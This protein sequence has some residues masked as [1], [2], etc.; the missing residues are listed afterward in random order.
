MGVKLRTLAIDCNDPELLAAFW[1]AVLDWH[2]VSRDEM[3]RFKSV[4]GT[5][6]M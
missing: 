5:T 1:S 2:I 3:E 6:P 4:P